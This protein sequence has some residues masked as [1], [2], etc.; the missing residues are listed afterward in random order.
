MALSSSGIGSNLD[1]N[2]IISQLMGVEQQPLQLLSRKEAS[3][4][5]KLSA[6]GSLKGALSSFQSAAKGLSDISKFQTVRVTPADATIASATGSATAVPG[7][8]AL[9]VTKLAQVQKLVAAGQASSSAAIGNGTIS[10]DFGTIS[11]GTFDSV[12]GKYTGATFASS[13]TGTKTVSISASNNSLAGIRDA[14]NGAK[15]GVTAAIVN[16]GGTSP[17]RLTLT[18]TSTGKT[19]SVKIAVTGDTALQT[20]LNHDP[21]AA[22]AGQ[23]LSETVTAQN[24]EFKLDG[25]AISKAGNTVTDVIQGVTLN[26]L[27]T[28]VSSPTSIAVTHDTGSVIGAVGQFVFAY[29][30]IS[31]TLTDLSAYNASTKQGAILNGDATVRNIQTQLRN[32]LTA[33]VAGG[34]S[35]Y[36]QLS[37]VGVTVQKDGTLAVDNT[38]LQSALDTNFSEIAGLFAATG[39]PT[40]S[41]VSYA[42]ATAKTKPGAYAVNVSQLARQASTTGSA[43]AGS[44]G[45]GSTTGSAAAGLSI[46]AAT[47]DTL[48]VALNGV[49]ATVTLTAGTYATAAALVTE[50]QTRINAAFGVGST[51]VSE[52][53]GVVK[54]T[55]A[56]TGTASSVS[57]TGGNGKANLLGASPTVVAGSETSVTTGTNDILQVQLDGVTTSITLAQGNY[58]FAALAAEVQSKINGAASFAAAGSAVTVTQTA[59][60]MKITSNRYSS[61]SSAAVTGGNGMLNLLGSA[62]TTVAGLDIAG[63]INGATATGSGQFLTGMTGDAAEGLKLQISSGAT[64]ARGTVNY[65]QGYAYQFDKLADSIL[66]VSGPISS[67]TDGLNASLKSIAQDKQRVA[68][69]LVSV[70]KRYRAQFTALDLIMSNMTKTSSFLTQQLSSLSNLSKS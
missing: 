66:D 14:I 2:G 65:S 53:N 24:A 25:I 32:I 43:A 13:G 58:S 68:D 69:R 67:R 51:T 64:G 9:E 52:T 29:N 22:P 70:E 48:L 21:A 42:G 57:L 54:I 46:T 55:A 26:L 15:I 31:K 12:A 11:G 27:K 6:I 41:L 63:T 37:Q 5:A 1:V 10:F 7:S 30:Q 61:A 59:G 3:F 16:D 17:Y 62:A 36:T 56:S 47:N 60:V 28:N 23:A 20:L 45:S 49:T 33:P 8:Y 44:P 40:D 18:E 4:Q 19:N 50:V 38:K 35:M 39:K 34:A